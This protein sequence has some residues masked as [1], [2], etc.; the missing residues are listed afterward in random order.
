MAPRGH[1]RS[2]LG[3]LDELAQLGVLQHRIGA[4]DRAVCRV[5]C[6]HGCVVKSRNGLL[7]S[8]LDPISADDDV[9][10]EDLAR[11]ESD[12]RPAWEGRVRL[13]VVH[14]GIEPDAHARGGARETEEHSVVIPTVDMVVWRAVIFNHACAP[15]L[16][17]DTGT[18]IVSTEHDSRGFYRERCE[19]L[20]EPPAVQESR[21]VGRDLETCAYVAENRCRLEERYAVSGVCERMCRGETADACA[22][23]DDVET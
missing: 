7:Q 16:V 17:P 14:S 1:P 2:H 9:R 12:T 20:A 6:G 13:Y 22:D 8:A 4:D 11:R 23:D 21:R 19:R 15:T 5:P 18:R 3:D 10:M